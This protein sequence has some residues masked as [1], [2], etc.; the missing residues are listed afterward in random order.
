MSREHKEKTRKT[1]TEA[2]QRRIKEREG[3]KARLLK[4]KPLMLLYVMQTTT[5]ELLCCFVIRLFFQYYN[6]AFDTQF[7]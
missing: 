1:I 5:T 6:S 4:E 2:Y 7:N 3:K